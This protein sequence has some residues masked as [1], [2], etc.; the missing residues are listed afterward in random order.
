M[1]GIGIWQLVI[2][3][4]IVFLLF[5]TKRLK[6]LGSDVG[7]AIQGFRKSMGGDNDVNAAGQAQ[8]Q[9]Q[10]PLNGQATQQ[11]QADRQ[12]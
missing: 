8:V 2:V 6:G 1:G 9:Q 5:G 7:E 4:L 12:A 10:A 3:L 11:P